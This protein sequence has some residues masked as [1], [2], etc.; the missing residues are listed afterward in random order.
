MSSDNA[1]ALVSKIGAG[2][3]VSAGEEGLWATFLPLLHVADGS[4]L[5]VMQGH[6]ARANNHWHVA[7]NDEPIEGLV[8][9]GGP[10]AYVSPSSYPSK[11]EHGRVVPTWNYV[12]VQIRGSL[13]FIHD[14]A[15]KLDLVTRLTNRHEEELVKQLDREQW[16]VN[17]APEQFIE[18]QLKAIVGVEMSIREVSGKAKLS[19]NRTED[20]RL[21]ALKQMDSNPQT[22]DVAVAMR[23]YGTDSGR[24]DW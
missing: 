11:Q 9:F 19:Q 16:K 15:W 1:L 23:T 8:L 24:I 5:G 17:D 10:D 14:H 12:D 2:H 18:S 22:R 21:G 20:D 4:P 13:R 6:I 7:L 3:L